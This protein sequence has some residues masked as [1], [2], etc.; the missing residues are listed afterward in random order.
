MSGYVDTIILE[1]NRQNSNQVGEAQSNA[2][3][4]N[5]I[6]SGIKLNV[7]DKISVHSAFVSDLGAEDSTIEF[8]G[9]VVQENQVFNI[10]D[11]FSIPLPN[12]I[13]IG[14]DYVVE[15]ERRKYAGETITETT[16]TIK[17]VKDN[18]A[19]IVVSYY[20]CLNGE[21]I[22]TLPLRHTL[23]TDDDNIAWVTVRGNETQALVDTINNGLPLA[24]FNV[25]I[26]YDDYCRLG[27]SGN[28]LAAPS[29]QP[30]QD[31]SRCMLFG[32]PKVSYIQIP[33]DL[34]T[35]N[36]VEYDTGVNK[37]R[38]L[39]GY[40]VKLI[41]IR[42]LL[43]L[44]VPLGFNSPSEIGSVIT[45][46]LQK[47]TEIKNQGIKFA[48]T[49]FGENCRIPFGS[50]S[51]ETSTNKLFNCAAFFD[52]NIGPANE[53]YGNT[54][55]IYPA[56]SGNIVR[57][58]ETGFQY[59]GIKRPEL[60]ITG[61]E[62]RDAILPRMTATTNPQTIA[63]SMA[64]YQD[65][66]KYY[67]KTPPGSFTNQLPIFHIPTYPN[68]NTIR[69]PNIVNSPS[70]PDDSWHRDNLNPLFT[71]F[72]EENPFGL[73]MENNGSP[74]PQA[75]TYNTATQTGA[76]YDDI[77]V[78]MDTTKPTFTDYDL[79]LYDITIECPT[80][81]LVAND[82][83][84]AVCKITA[85]NN[86]PD[87]IDPYF[88][89]EFDGTASV[90][91]PF[92]TAVTITRYVNRTRVLPT[93]Y[94]VI[95]TSME[96]TL[97]NLK[98]IFKF[99]K[100][101]ERTPELMTFKDK[102]TDS[103]YYTNTQTYITDYYN[104][105]LITPDTHR[106]FH[107]QGQQNEATPKEMA[108][109]SLNDINAIPTFFSP[110]SDAYEATT[111][112][113]DFVST[114]F[115]YDNI[116]SSFSDKGVANGTVN[117]YG[118]DFSSFPFFVKYFKDIA[119]SRDWE[120]MTQEE[121]D[122]TVYPNGKNVPYRCSPETLKEDVGKNLWG[123]FAIRN[124]SSCQ[125]VPRVGAS[126]AYPNDRVFASYAGTVNDHME[127]IKSYE[128]NKFLKQVDFTSNDNIDPDWKDTYT[129]SI[130]D[131]ISFVCQLPYANNA[132]A[133]EF[134]SMMRKQNIYTQ[135][136]E[137]GIYEPDSVPTQREISTPY[138]IDWW[139]DVLSQNVGAYPTP[140]RIELQTRTRRFGYDT[141]PTAYGNLFTGLYNGIMGDNGVS[142]LQEY[143]V[144][145]DKK[146]YNNNARTDTV[147]ND[148][149]NPHDYAQASPEYVSKYITDV[150]IGADAPEFAFDTTTSRFSF[151][152]LHTSEKI[153]AKYNATLIT[154]NQGKS[155]TG[156]LQAGPVPVPDNLGKN[157]YR[158][159]K[160][161]DFRNFCPSITPY[162]DAIALQLTGTQEAEMF[163]YNNPYVK[164]GNIIDSHSGIFL[165]QFG[166]DE[167]N[168][169]RSFWGICGFS[170]ND[171]NTNESKGSINQRI[172][173]GQLNDISLITTNQD[174]EN[175]SMDEWF[176]PLTGV[177]NHKP[178]LPFPTL[179][180]F[181]Q[182][183][184]TTRFQL[185][186]PVEVESISAKIEATNLPTKTL[187]PYFT[188]RSDIITDDK[189]HGH[190]KAVLPVVEVLQKESQ[191][192]D[193]FYGEGSTEFTNT[194]PRT[195]TSVKTSICDPNG[196][197]ASLS[198]NSAVLYKIQKQ[199]NAS[200]N[201]ASEV[202]NNLKKK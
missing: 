6:S 166:I 108:L 159:N 18:V 183:G 175:S 99:F 17:N 45:D 194:F 47:N 51:N 189:F 26:L 10:T 106:L 8:K 9:S 201:V 100:A 136:N 196:K 122:R 66:L 162:F 21:Y 76:G 165:D 130:Y 185:L 12:D 33:S 119:D 38:D 146:F 176:G 81:P 74:A 57:F 163:A 135:I 164:Q 14:A 82:G 1:A 97:D 94:T 86:F 70:V 61:L 3:W 198:P 60:Y 124:P 111:P 27:E 59:I 87:A 200:L 186:A 148:S 72:L 25:K 151:S 56:S 137:Y 158:I 11:T 69:Y 96:W 95:N 177:A 90:Q 92:N 73:W 143:E 140:E 24:Q 30:H 132:V 32:R 41:K 43:E 118:K 182:V 71:N 202:L 68:A 142:P 65:T 184:H 62:L 126:A 191:Y 192:G 49:L 34:Q 29:I 161:F 42:D 85:I 187:R 190:D 44:E 84:G 98:K 13:L 113:S 101:Q 23:G 170:F 103:F 80:H 134:P 168:W 50:S 145:V 139:A 116:K 20:T 193:F 112:D 36:G 28:A 179:A 195:I 154:N 160:V 167:K 31:G 180:Q 133:S 5:E 15:Y 123:G 105:E 88:N 171:L 125:F 89:V 104:G 131:C 83:S 120:N 48:N 155:D 54:G 63:P 91:I 141:H 172:V 77:N 178:C 40:T 115:G 58:Y 152:G 102:T 114:S 37:Y 109:P 55:D 93:P 64:T 147:F 181:T 7:G 129:N 173:S 22:Q 150:Y 16:K 46:Q 35:I 4:V 75:I 156:Q 52:T 121:F 153:T 169:N 188:I 157:C 199:N 127:V 174:V 149:A 197:L 39:Y 144:A 138:F 67:L 128:N 117:T 79:T 2:E 78:L 110:T 53:W 107:L 19:N